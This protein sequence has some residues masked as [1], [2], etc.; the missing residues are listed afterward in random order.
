MD[1]DL[2]TTSLQHEELIGVN[3]N[4]KEICSVL[5]GSDIYEG[6]AKAAQDAVIS[7]ETFNVHAG[8]PGKFWRVLH[9]STAVETHWGLNQ[10]PYQLPNVKVWMSTPTASEADGDQSQ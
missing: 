8:E 1:K 2:A 4:H 5:E 10:E 6:I 9:E 7:F 3:L